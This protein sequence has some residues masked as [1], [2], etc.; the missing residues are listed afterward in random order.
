MAV[1]TALSATLLRSVPPLKTPTICAS[2]H[3]KLFAIGLMFA[4]SLVC[5]TQALTVMDV[6][7]IQMLKTINPA[8]IYAMGLTIGIEEFSAAVTGSIFVV[9]AGVAMTVFGAKNFT[10][11]GI[12]LQLVS[13]CL[14][15]ARWACLQQVMQ[16]DVARLTPLHTLSLIAPNAAIVLW[17]FATYIEMSDL[18]HDP[19]ALNQM[20]W[21]MGSSILAFM[22]NLCSFEFVRATSALRMSITGVIKDVL[23]ILVSGHMFHTH[24]S[25][26]QIQGYMTAVAGVCLYNYLHVRREK[27]D[28]V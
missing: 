17:A 18:F 19:D 1:A 22:L 8:V 4:L 24:V 13:V 3:A 20:Y 27:S 9:C 25:V 23:L 15:S 6:S 26:I 5:A 12:A 2:T 28:D 14:D 7:S 21:V 16:D 11:Y 10:P